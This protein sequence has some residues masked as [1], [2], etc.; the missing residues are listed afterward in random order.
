MSASADSEDD[1]LITMF[2][3]M[4]DLIRNPAELIVNLISTFDGEY[5]AAIIDKFL[6]DN[7]E[8][9]ITDIHLAGNEY[10]QLRRDTLYARLERIETGE[11]VVQATLE[12]ILGAIRNR[13]YNT[14]GVTV[15]YEEGKKR[16]KGIKF[17]RVSFD[18]AEKNIV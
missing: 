4:L 17:S 7:P 15:S 18:I 11:T 5:I 10:G 14:L 16:F 6:V 12:Y 9:M 1:T 13:G 3:D 2:V 8:Y